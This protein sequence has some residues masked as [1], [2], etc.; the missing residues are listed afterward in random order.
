MRTGRMTLC[1]CQP[2]CQDEANRDP[3][4]KLTIWLGQ[5]SSGIISFGIASYGIKACGMTGCRIPYYPDIGRSKPGGLLVPH[6]MA[7]LVLHWDTANLFQAEAG[8]YKY[9][10][11]SFP[12][13][14]NSAAY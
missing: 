10:L 4:S 14:N 12:H 5:V 11:P 1:S 7:Y 8:R 3:S 6:E 2:G 13:R 9:R